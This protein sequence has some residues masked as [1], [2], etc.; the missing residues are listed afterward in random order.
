MA[1]KVGLEPTVVPFLSLL[2]VAFLCGHLL[3][4]IRQ[5]IN[6]IKG[7]IATTCNLRQKNL[8]G[9]VRLPTDCAGLCGG[10]KLCGICAVTGR[11]QGG[12]AMTSS[13]RYGAIVQAVRVMNSSEIAAP[14]LDTGWGAEIATGVPSR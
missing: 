2:I 4:W 14:G 10:K 1:P 11:L 12:G 5:K 6:D 13:F 7:I 3:L 8:C 9:I